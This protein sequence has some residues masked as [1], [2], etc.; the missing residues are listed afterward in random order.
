[1]FGLNFELYI[2]LNLEK[3][4]Y[5]EKWEYGWLKLWFWVMVVMGGV[6][7]KLGE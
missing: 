6:F 7:G 3:F 1:M 5:R 4:R 2:G